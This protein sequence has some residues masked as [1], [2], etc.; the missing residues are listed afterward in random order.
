ME[1]SHRKSG[2][3][4][5]RAWDARSIGQRI[6]STTTDSLLADMKSVSSPSAYLVFSIACLLGPACEAQFD[7]LSDQPLDLQQQAFVSQEMN[8]LLLYCCGV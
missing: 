1:T 8:I 6:P 5:L 2:S 4:N 3:R 7:G